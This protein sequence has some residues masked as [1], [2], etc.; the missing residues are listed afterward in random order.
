MGMM[1]VAGTEVSET[2]ASTFRMPSTESVE[3]ILV[4]SISG[5]SL[6][7]QVC[8]VNVSTYKETMFSDTETDVI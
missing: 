7:I 2:G 1:T 3:A 5:G 6:K 8:V 4:A